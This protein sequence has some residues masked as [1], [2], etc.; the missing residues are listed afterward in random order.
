[1]QLLDVGGLLK[2]VSRPD[3]THQAGDVQQWKCRQPE[4]IFQRKNRKNI[5]YV[6]TGASKWGYNHFTSWF[7]N[8]AI[9]LP[10][11]YAELHDK[12]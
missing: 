9:I 8:L 4:H 3:L 5:T 12:F 1:M 7:T 6:F 11:V 10:E 2:A